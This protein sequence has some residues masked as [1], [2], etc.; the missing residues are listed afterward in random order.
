MENLIAREPEPD[1]AMR[2]RVAKA[3]AIGVGALSAMGAYS[4][5][6]ISK[7]EK[8][9]EVAHQVISA[10]D[11]HGSR[12]VIQSESEESLHKERRD[13]SIEPQD[14]IGREK[15][16][17]SLE[18]AQWWPTD[19]KSNWLGIQ[20]KATEYKIDPYL[21]ATIVAEE[22]MGKNIQNQSGATG[23]MQIM[24]STAQEI[25]RLRHRTYYD[26]TDIDQN[27]D[28]GCWLIQYLN[29]KYIAPRGVDITSDLGISMLG[30][31]YGDGEG[32]GELWVKNG[33][34]PNYLSVQAQQ[35]IPLWQSMYRDRNS[36]KSEVY[37]AKRGN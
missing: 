30:V 12:S 11:E 28:Y 2:K 4:T 8:P 19:V 23:L 21:V 36:Q 32:A 20:A 7:V 31:Y 27:L 3:G 37:A 10:E 14:D 9:T 24:P 26:M 17:K 35:V 34:S 16:L 33:Y 18:P 29:E 6:Q 15:Q 1:Q 13:P 22:S 25:A 5:N